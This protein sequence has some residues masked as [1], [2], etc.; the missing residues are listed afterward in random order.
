[1]LAFLVF[2]ALGNP[3]AP[4]GIA[5]TD[6]AFAMR[7]LGARGTYTPFRKQRRWE[8]IETNGKER[9]SVHELREAVQPLQVIAVEVFLNVQTVGW[10]RPYVF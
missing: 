10:R 2:D 8:R 1:M 4:Q 5:K 6:P 7:T 3:V 9:L